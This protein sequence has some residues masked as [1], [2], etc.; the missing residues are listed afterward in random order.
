MEIFVLCYVF[1]AIFSKFEIKLENS[2][3]IQNHFSID[4]VIYYHSKDILNF[5]LSTLCVI[6]SVGVCSFIWCTNNSKIKII[7]EIRKSTEVSLCA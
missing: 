2:D 1:D 7:S 3:D 5:D 6:Y 4:G